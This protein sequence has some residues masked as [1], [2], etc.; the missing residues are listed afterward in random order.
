[1][2]VGDVIERIRFSHWGGM[3]FTGWLGVILKKTYS[4]YDST[5]D[6]WDVLMDSEIVSLQT[7]QMRKIK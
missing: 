7:R 1:M 4:A 5:Y 6:K 2:N 3:H